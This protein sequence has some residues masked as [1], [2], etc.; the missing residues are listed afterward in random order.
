[1]TVELVDADG[2]VAA[3][4]AATWPAGVG[5]MYFGPSRRISATEVRL[6][7]S[8]P[9]TNLCVENLEIGLP[10]VNG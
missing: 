7:S 9:A 6:R 1:M 8:D 4:P 2:N 10:R 3:M 5:T